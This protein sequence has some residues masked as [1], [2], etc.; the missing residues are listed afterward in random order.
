MNERKIPSIIYGNVLEVPMTTRRIRHIGGGSI[1]HKV[2]TAILGEELW[3]RP[4]RKSLDEMILLAK[5]V[6]KEGSDYL[7]FMIHSSELMPGGS[8]YFTTK[9]D[10]NNM[11]DIV[12]RFFAFV[13]E[14][15]Y[16]GIGLSD[17]AKFK[18]VN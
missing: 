11:Y 14:N 13:N 12:E 10:I 16:C 17:Y 5:H 15:G 6:E 8:P 1:K 18:K 9:D 2:K 7:E 3:L 4:Y